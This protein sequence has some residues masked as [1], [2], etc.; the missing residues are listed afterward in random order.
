MI[1][2]SLLLTL[3]LLV[4]GYGETL[5]LNAL[6]SPILFRGDATTAYRDPA[7]LYDNGTFWL[8][9]SYVTIDPDKKAYD[10]LAWTKSQD[11]IH[12]T[13]VVPFTPKDRHL[14]YSSPGDIVRFGGQWVLCAQTY[15]RPNGE[16]Y[17]NAD[18]RL[19]LFRSADLEHWSEPELLQ[20]KGPDVPREKMGRMIDPFLIQDKDDPNTWWCFYKQN[21]ISLSWSHDLKNWTCFGRINAG[22]NPCVI[23]DNGE[24]VL[25][26][27]PTTGIGIKRSS[28]LK[29]WRDEGVLMLGEKDWPWAHGRL[30][31]GFLLDLRKDPRVGKVLLFFHGSDYPEDDPQGGFDNYASIGV[32]WSDDLKHWDWPG[33]K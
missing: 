32:A 25:S 19:W 24:Y 6:T 10:Q 31:A 22:E 29:N 5:N 15:P 14:N 17:G 30:T 26:H 12:W 21:G 27:S 7:V 33:K 16:R 23:L 20:V 13:P 4:N 1:R 18:S 28:D 3:A 8:I 9:I 2:L 11:L